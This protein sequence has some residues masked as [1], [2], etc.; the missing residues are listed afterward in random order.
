M[1]NFKDFINNT[2]LE[3]PNVPKNTNKNLRAAFYFS[4]RNA[5]HGCRIKVNCDYSNDFN[6]NIY[7]TVTVPE[8]IIIGRTGKIKQRDINYFKEFVEI[9]KKVLLNFWDGKI[10]EDEAYK[11]FKYEW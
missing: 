9:N 4:P 7:F 6:K 8:G 2:V 1:R 3:E 5:N 10:T 11:G